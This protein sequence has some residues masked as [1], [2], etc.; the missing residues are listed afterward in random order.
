MN[1]L[2]WWSGILV[3]FF[4]LVLIRV[5]LPLPFTNEIIIFSIYVMGCSFLLGRV[6]FISFGQPAY[7]AT[8]AYATA[9]YL[10]YFGTNPFIGILVG[11]AAGF[12]MAAHRRPALRPAAERLFRPG[13]PGAGGDHLLHDAEG[14]GADHPGGQRAV[15]FDQHEI[16]AHPRHHP[17]EG[18]LHLRLSGR[19]GDL[20]ASTNTSTTPSTAPAAWPPRSTRTRSSFSATATSRSACWPSSSPTRRRPW[21][22]RCT[23]STWASSAPR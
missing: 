9:F 21:P 14:A 17:A 16:H 4:L 13:Q 23:P 5:F 22:A 18:V 20:G 7:L 15:V 19:A 1:T 2:R 12:V 6:G 3:A 11:I 8:G 10:F